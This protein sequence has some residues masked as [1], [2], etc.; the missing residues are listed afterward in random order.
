MRWAVVVVAAAAALLES[1]CAYTVRTACAA[2][3]MTQ[4]LTQVQMVVAHRGASAYLPENTLAAFRLADSMGA[5]AFELD[6]QMTSDGVVRHA[7]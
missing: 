2:G 4:G 1:A 7:W 3:H 5:D 6:V